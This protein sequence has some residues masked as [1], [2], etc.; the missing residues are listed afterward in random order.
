MKV[1][2]GGGPVQLGCASDDVTDDERSH[3]WPMFLPDGHSFLFWAGNFSTDG[4]A[5]SGIYL[6]SGSSVDVLALNQA[7]DARHFP[8]HRPP[9]RRMAACRRRKFA[10]CAGD[11]ERTPCSSGRG[12]ISTASRLNAGQIFGNARLDHRR[13]IMYHLVLNL[14]LFPALA[15]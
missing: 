6:S 7:L 14:D 1:R 3:R 8:G 13:A 15:S 10:S 11:R 2:A 9:S 4:A 12:R 5:R